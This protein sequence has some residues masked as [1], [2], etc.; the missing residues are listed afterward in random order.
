MNKQK[1]IRKQTINSKQKKQKP[2]GIVAEWTWKLCACSLYEHWGHQAKN[3]LPEI[4]NKQ[5]K[6]AVAIYSLLPFF[7]GGSETSFTCWLRNFCGLPS[8]RQ[9]W[10]LSMNMWYIL[11]VSVEVVS[12][13]LFIHCRAFWK[14]VRLH[15]WNKQ[16]SLT[17]IVSSQKT[18]NEGWLMD[19]TEMC[20]SDN[21]QRF[22]QQPS[23]EDIFINFSRRFRNK[24]SIWTWY[25]EK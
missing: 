24:Q 23:T 4:T 15:K 21:L 1:K 5:A 9:C 16:E 17:R 13:T 18:M 12:C 22:L 11:K 20:F 3:K 25:L 2:W 10:M 7:G 6:V 19:A 14:L 8:L